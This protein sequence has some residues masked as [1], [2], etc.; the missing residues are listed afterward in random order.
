MRLNLI[1]TK[2]QLKKFE[3]R[4]KSKDKL[5]E[6]LDMLGLEKLQSE[7]EYLKVRGTFTHAVF[8]IFFK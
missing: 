2:I 3:E 1:K 6:E 5:D 4:M 8:L 7:N